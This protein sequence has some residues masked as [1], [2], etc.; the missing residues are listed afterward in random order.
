MDGWCKPAKKPPPKKNMSLLCYCFSALAE[1][2]DLYL[3]I[4]NRKY[5]NI[6]IIIIQSLTIHEQVS[7][8]P[9]MTPVVVVRRLKMVDC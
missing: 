6:I 2:P 9:Q 7:K 3:K 1:H 5:Q 8:C 4:I